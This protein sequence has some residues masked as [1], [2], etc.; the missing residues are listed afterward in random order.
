MLSDWVKGWR[1]KNGWLNG[2]SALALRVSAVDTWE[3]FSTM[4]M[5]LVSYVE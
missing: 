4:S 1:G 2:G 5:D 3:I